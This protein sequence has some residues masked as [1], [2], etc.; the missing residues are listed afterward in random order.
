MFSVFYLVFAWVVL[1]DVVVRTSIILACLGVK[2]DDF[3]EG[4][5]L[6]IRPDNVIKLNGML[7]KS[8]VSSS[9][10]NSGSP[11][12][13]DLTQNILLYNNTLKILCMKTINASPPPIAPF[14]S[15]A[16]KELCM[17]NKVV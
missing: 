7:H 12:C 5:A 6:I 8:L 2:R 14:Y 1:Y 16:L 15:L 13:F 11:V 4:S 3:N 10:T 17:D 9:N